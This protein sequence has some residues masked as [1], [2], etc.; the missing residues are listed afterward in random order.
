MRR[1]LVLLV[2]AVLT[3][4][5][6][7]A[8]AELQN[9]EVGGEIHIRGNWIHNTL[10]SPAPTEVR[11]A[12][13]NLW[14]RPIGGPF[15]ALGVL[16]PL[17]WSDRSHNTKLVEMRTRLNVGAEFT[18]QV[19][20]FIELDSYD[21]WGTDFRSVNYI[22][23]ID[24]PANS[25][26]DVEVFQAY[27]E[28][29]EMFGY[30]LRLR[31][32][33]QELRLG[34]EWL[35]GDGNVA[36]MFTGT[37]F[38]GIRLTYATDVFSID[39]FWTKLAEMSPAEEDGDIDFYGIY[40]SYLGVEDVT[41]DA[42][43][44]LLRDARQLQD[45]PYSL[46]GSWIEDVLDLDDY[47]VTNLHTVGLRAS[48]KYGAFDFEA[49]VA[50][51][52]GDYGQLGF[53]FKPAVYGDD[54]A[55]ASSW[56]THLEAG[57]SFD[58]SCHPRIFAGFIYFDGEDNRDISFWEWLNPFDLPDASV[59]FNRLFSDRLYSGFVDLNN[60]Y[61][62]GW[63]ARIGVNAMPTEKLFMMLCISRF[64]SVEEF[65]APIHFKLWRWRVPWV[66]NLSFWTEE[67]DSYLGTEAYLMLQ[68]QYTED[69][70]FE[71]GWAHWF[72]S[73]GMDDG[74]FNLWNG[75]VFG[76]GRADGGEDGDYVY[77]GT[78]LKF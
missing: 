48:G 53:T 74:N 39:G 77:V 38:D 17:M 8:T 57:Y 59:S 15:A 24:A 22:T 29:N 66:P 25:V 27:I 56:A 36:P 35:V 21:V 65:D 4:A 34:A 42:Y 64:E 37:S 28:A 50:Y 69:L 11:W 40:A 13:N 45:T 75:T 9:V 51:Q 62:N 52:F 68:Y 32:G 70:M 6:M 30:P 43:W 49:E 19:A 12:R 46:V 78:K 72:N 55:D 10:T 23:G 3:A 2:A 14:Q 20:A 76:G 26:D 60:D 16:S 41:L 63:I 67:N 58:Y 73:D 44:L 18:D 33:R 71:A 47:D 61:S 54:G 1:M 5:A 31:I 7:P